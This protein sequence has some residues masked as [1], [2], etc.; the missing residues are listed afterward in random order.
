MYISFVILTKIVKIFRL[1]LLY[2]KDESFAHGFQRRVYVS[3]DKGILA[4]EWARTDWSQGTHT[5]EQVKQMLTRIMEGTEV[6]AMDIC[7]EISPSKC[8]TWE[9]SL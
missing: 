8:P 6:A 7:G 5:L 1:F 2:L 3:L 9:K 4:R